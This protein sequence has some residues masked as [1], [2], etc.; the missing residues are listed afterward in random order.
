MIAKVPPSNRHFGFLFCGIFILLS[1]FFWY[2]G[3][4]FVV[5]CGLLVVGLVIGLVSIMAP[6]L[7]TPFN[8]AWMKLGELMGKIISPIV[9]GI[10]FFT[11]LTPTGLL[12]RFFGRDE[13]RLRKT[14]AGS[15][16]IDRAPPGPTGDS[17]KNQF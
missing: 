11:L 12:G 9:L 4:S 16:W 13:L 17:F 14:K 3:E 5:V 10:I 15:Y 2:V 8:R 7:L 6:D 1:A